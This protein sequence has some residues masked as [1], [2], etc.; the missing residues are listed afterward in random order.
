VNVDV[1][2]IRILELR[3]GAYTEVAYAEGDAAVEVDRPFPVR[4][5]P[6]A[7]VTV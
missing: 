1:P 2:S 6:R 3:A 7:L 5:V 4:L